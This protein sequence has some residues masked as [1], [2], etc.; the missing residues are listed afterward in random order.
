MNTLI[1]KI[2]ERDDYHKVG[3]ILCHNGVVRGTSR[4]GSPVGSV[5]VRADRET[6]EAIV[7]EQKKRPGIIEILYEVNEG[8]LKVGD[9]LLMIVVAGDIREH[10]IPVMTDTLNAIKAR[11]TKKQEHR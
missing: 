7:E 4:D 9:D 10:V 5:D 6:I 8:N 11:G 1:R 2:K 3:M